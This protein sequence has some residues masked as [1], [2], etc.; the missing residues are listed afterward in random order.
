[1]KQ[2]FSSRTFVELSFGNEISTKWRSFLYGNFAEK[3]SNC[4]ANF[5]GKFARTK[6][7]IRVGQTQQFSTRYL[8]YSLPKPK[9]YSLYK[10]SIICFWYFLL[11]N[12][13]KC[14]SDQ[15]FKALLFSASLIMSSLRPVYTGDFCRSNSMQFLS[16]E[17][18]TS[19]S[20]V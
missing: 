2:R 5:R 3:A 17:V 11:Y 16:R 12:R 1:M 6:N 4:H 19:K 8:R 15:P 14:I 13:L 10:L 20:H 9:C 18:V 7:E